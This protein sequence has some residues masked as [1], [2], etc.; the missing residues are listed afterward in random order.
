[1]CKYLIHYFSG[2]G[3][4]YHM[5]KTIESQLRSMG[6]EVDLL[7]IEKDKDVNL[8][9]YELH[10]FCFPVYGFGTPSIM[11]KYISK[12]KSSNECKAVVLCTSAGAEGQSLSH[13]KRILDKKGFKVFFTDMV[14]YTYNFTQIL[15]PQSKEVE[16]RA[17]KDAE[18]AIIEI[19]KRIVNNEE[20]FKKINIIA[21]TLSWVIFIM[22]IN[23]GR[24]ILG[25]TFIADD[26]CINCGKCEKACPA[27]VISMHN[28]KPK[29][30]SNCESCQRCINTCPKKSIQLSIVKLA[31]FIIS[32]LAPILIIIDIN[33][34]MY[35]LPVII[36][37]VLYCAMFVI[38]T[39][40]ASILISLMERLHIFKKVFNISY[41]KR[42]RRNIAKGFNIK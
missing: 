30:S 34:Y 25:K 26:A 41:T 23:L 28:G 31:I 6:F 9:D 36:N 29:W 24:R 10:I 35:H 15:N 21:L 22:F 27:K 38:S 5:V 37:I 32:E 7:N 20:S 12:I 17:F 8:N 39:V 3:N 40:I 42:Y 1:M 33:N 11:L 13:V 18:A 4:T 2:T 14:V 19:T 16:E